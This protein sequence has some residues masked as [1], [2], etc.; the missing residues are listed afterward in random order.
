MRRPGVRVRLG[1]QR[2]WTVIMMSMLQGH[3]C[4]AFSLGARSG[5]KKHHLS[6]QSPTTSP[7]QAQWP[8]GTTNARDGRSILRSTAMPSAAASGGGQAGIDERQQTGDREQGED[9][10]EAK[11]SKFQW[12]RQWYPVAVI[13]D[14]E[15]R[16]PRQPYPVQLLGEAL[17]VWKD[18][19]DGG[20][21]AFAD[22]CPHRWAPLSEG[23]VDQKTGR[24]QCIYHG[25]EFQGDG[26]CGAIPQ[27]NP[28]A[29]ETAQNSK[30]RVAV[31]LAAACATVIPT[32]IV[33]GKL[34][35]WP[36]S[37]PEGVE[38]SN[39]VAPA[40]VSDLDLENGE[41]GGNWYARDLAYGHD[42]LL[43]N[44]IDPAHLPFAHHGVIS[45]RANG[46]PMTTEI[47]Q[48]ASAGVD[49]FSTKPTGYNGKKNLVVTFKAPS[50][51]YYYNDFTEVVPFMAKGLSPP[52]RAVVWAMKKFNL[53]KRVAMALEGTTKDLDDRCLFYFIGYAVPT[54]PGR[55]RIFTRS[56]RNFFLQHPVIPRRWRNS[57]S[58]EHRSQHLV[59]DGDSTALHMQERFLL[60]ADQQGVKRPESTFFM[61]TTSD[62]TIQAFRKWYNSRGAGGP[63]WA[64]G[65]DPSDLGPVLPREK[66]LDRMDAHSKDCSACSKAYGVSGKVK[67]AAMGGALLLLAGA[68]AAPRG[69]LALKLVGGALANAG[70][71]V[72][73]AKRQQ[74]FVFVDYVHFNRD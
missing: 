59:L 1:G 53:D 14:L 70:L 27:A 32:R 51:V 71:A 72:A 68:A 58:K 47:D 69:A 23:R 44:L 29:R 66:I 6:L 21:K 13:R 60:G 43:E 67:K 39:T 36:D 49:E 4:S 63:P 12:A 20:W 31:D 9:E 61:P 16:D 40:V 8:A 3:V 30:R 33:Q 50:L 62:K 38:A 10:E 56:P 74:Q 24:L 73:M 64:K 7:T 34:W 65:I 45:Q 52:L 25:W 46:T 22:R 37:S 48:E 2:I 28:G 15:A 41:W 57:L 54:S 18:P 55:C 35:L 17:V 19:G 5:I 26:K 42:T 11:E